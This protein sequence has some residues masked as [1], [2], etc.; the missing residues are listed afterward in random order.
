MML[1]KPSDK[2]KLSKIEI[3][4]KKY[5]KLIA[6]RRKRREQDERGK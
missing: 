1:K 5:R 4:R 2:L 6:E 3:I